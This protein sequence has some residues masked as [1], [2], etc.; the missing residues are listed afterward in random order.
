MTDE[1]PNPSAT[2]DPTPDPAQTPS[3]P[4]SEAAATPEPVKP[5]AA[6]GAEPETK[7]PEAKPAWGDD[8]RQKMAEHAS[9]GDKKAYDRELKRLERF[10]DPTAVYGMYRELEGKFSQGGLVKVPG[11]DASEDDIK[12]FNKAIGVPEDPKAYVE[13]LSLPNGV[14]LGDRDKV[15]AGDFAS[16]L[17]KAGA[18]QSVMNE[19]MGWYLRNEE[20]RAAEIDRQDDDNKRSGVQELK[21]EWGP[22]YNRNINAISSLFAYAPGGADMENEGAL[23]NRLLGGRMADGRIIGDDPGMVKFLVSLAKEVNPVATV[24]EAADGSGRGIDE[25]IKEIETL[26]R[27][28]RRAYDKDTKK[29]SRY[30]ELIGAREK[31]RARA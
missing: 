21:E 10:S 28:D 29:Q 5:I 19:A 27:T 15:L 3:A 4:A 8:W 18:P 11:K 22:A 24:V 26:M 13:N 25:E 30:L 7:E 2:P 16:A 23:F 14:T 31:H 20:A 9:A 6:G 12:A 1:N 17:H